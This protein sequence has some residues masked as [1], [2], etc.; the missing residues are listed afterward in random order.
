MLCSV[1]YKRINLFL[2]HEKNEKNNYFEHAG[3]FCS[4][5]L[6]RGKRS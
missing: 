4:Q 6:W 1:I 2:R 3:Y 5:C